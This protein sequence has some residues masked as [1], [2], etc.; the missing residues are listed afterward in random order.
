MT[1]LVDCNMEGQASLLWDTLVKEGWHELLPV[2]MVMFK[3]VDLALDSVD[4]YVWRFAQ[5]NQ[6]ILLTDNRSSNEEE[7]LEQTIR[8]ENTSNSLPVLTIG[9]VSRVIEKDYRI[10]C[11]ERLVE[12]VMDLDNYMGTARIF[13]P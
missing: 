1:I 12:I 7:S 5:A 6:M 13:I 11:I 9:N 2:Q 10:R 3:D 8:Q 4:R